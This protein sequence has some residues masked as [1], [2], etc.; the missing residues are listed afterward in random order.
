MPQ[1]HIVDEDGEIAVWLDT[2]GSMKDGTII[3]S[4]PTQDIALRNAR[5]TLLELVGE[6]EDMASDDED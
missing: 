5:G 4:G 6:L 3:G 2:E 1:L